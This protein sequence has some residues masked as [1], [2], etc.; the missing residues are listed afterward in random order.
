MKLLKSKKG[1]IVLA[2]AVVLVIWA[3]SLVRDDIEVSLVEQIETRG[4]RILGAR[5]NVVGASVDWAAGDV[6]LSKLVVAS[7]G[8]FS[9]QDMI[10]VDTVD[11]RAGLDARRIER[12]TLRG[13]DVL[14]EFRG[15]KSNFETVSDRIAR[16]AARDD[17]GDGSGWDA[18]DR[19]TTESESE[20]EGDEG[21]VTD[22]DQP[23]DDW[24]V[25]EVVFEDIQ[26]RVQADWSS[27]VIDIDAGDLSIANLDA[28]TDDLVRAVSLRFVHRVLASAAEQ[29]DD[30][31]LRK[32]LMEK[33]EDLRARVQ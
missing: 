22:E 2:V 23:R 28:G 33:A 4:S 31:R 13:V 19:E 29:V 18:V 21:T 27:K 32:A 9:N 26:V 5:V 7:P 24:R 1:L 3:V 16:R 6:S 30:E 12:V 15:A 17:A 11:A 25:D 10:S 20:S 8:G 14:V